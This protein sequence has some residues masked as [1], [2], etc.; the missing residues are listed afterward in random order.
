M[1][2]APRGPIVTLIGSEGDIDDHRR[3]PRC[4]CLGCR[5]AVGYCDIVADIAQPY[6]IPVICALLGAPQTDWRMISDWTDDIFKMFWWDVAEHESEILTAW[7]QFDDYIDAMIKERRTTL[8]DDLLSD[9]IRAE[10]NGDRLSH[11]ELLMLSM[12]ILAA[13]TDTTRNQLAAAVYILCEHP[14]QWALLGAH[15]ELV[16][17]A[18]DEVMRFTPI[19]LNVPR[20]VTEDVELAGY[21]FP[22][23]SLVIANTAAANRD[24]DVYKDPDQFDV[25]RHDA[26]PMLTFGGGVHY[27]LGSH[28]ARLELVRALTVLTQR[29][30]NIRRTGPAPWKPL[31]AVSGPQTLP[32][33]F[34]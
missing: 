30:P 5:A 1:S 28:L 6:P 32:V 19:V 11:S 3:Q 22:R 16:P 2:Y 25:T 10:D 14:D 31:M 9:L 29:M 15:P 34:D 33:A 26:P 12:G 23:G 4:Q 24:P 27:C 21:L 18:V 17:Q 20:Y 13:G 7:Q 8:T